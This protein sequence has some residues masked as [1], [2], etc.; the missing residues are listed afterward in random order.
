MINDDDDDTPNSCN[1][2]NAKERNS[3]IM[4]KLL[5]PAQNL[6]NDDNNDSTTNL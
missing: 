5:T 1:S 6:H 3:A 4:L 2:I